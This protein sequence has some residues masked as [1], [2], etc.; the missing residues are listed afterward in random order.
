M[1]EK[2]IVVGAGAAGI[3]ATWLLR[4]KGVDVTCYEAA[5]HPCGRTRAYVKDGYICETGALGVETQWEHEPALIKAVGLQDEY[6]PGT[7]MRVGFWRKNKLNLIGLGTF[8]QQLRWL[9]QTLGFRGIPIKA[10]LQALNVVKAIQGELKQIEAEGKDVRANGFEALEKFGDTNLADYVLEHGGQEALDYVFQ[11]IM[12]LLI[13]GSAKDTC[14]VHMMCLLINNSEGVSESGGFGWMKRGIGSIYEAAYQMDQECYRLSSPV[15]EIVIEGGKARGVLVRD[16]LHR[17]DHVICCTTASQAAKLMPDLPR[18]IK[19]DLAAVRY[20][21]TYHYMFGDPKKFTPEEFTMEFFA[22][23]PE[24]PNPLI[25][26]CLDAAQRSECYTPNGGGTLLHVL[27]SYEHDPYLKGLD[28]E[29][30]CKVVMDETR[31][32]FPDMPERPELVECLYLDEA[33]SLDAPG[34]MPAIRDYE[35]EHI[36]DVS[37][38]YLAGEYMHP[39]ASAEGACITAD[40]AVKRLISNLREV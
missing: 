18:E 26:V 40:R 34:Q 22:S 2:V 14:V 13:L 11:P 1:T 16:E 6:G 37:G 24:D 21:S 33:I 4:R 8:G 31:N 3:Y 12:S 5:E 25:R 29:Q 35:G 17:A 28:A 32:L 39:A 23:T 38:L 36:D 9:P 19:D 30:R 7:T 20:A 15:E 27:T 10:L